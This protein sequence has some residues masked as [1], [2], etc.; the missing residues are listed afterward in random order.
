[1]ARIHTYLTEEVVIQ[2]LDAIEPHATGIAEARAALGLRAGINVVIEM[3]GERDTEDGGIHV[4]T[5]AI[6]YTADTLK[7]LARLDIMID[8]DQYVY[9]PD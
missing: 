1:M 3:S 5:A 6:T 2:L 7:R 4:S 8:H 9:L